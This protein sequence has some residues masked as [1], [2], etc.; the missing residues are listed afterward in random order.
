[1]VMINS[2]SYQ[3]NNALQKSTQSQ[4]YD[5]FSMTAQDYFFLIQIH[6]WL[7][8]FFPLTIQVERHFF[9]N[10]LISQEGLAEIVPVLKAC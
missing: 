8:P 1:M 9:P 4:I 3:T 6:F 5:S 10:E 7:V 2:E